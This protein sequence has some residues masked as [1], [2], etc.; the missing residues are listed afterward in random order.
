VFHFGRAIL[1]PQQDFYHAETGPL[2]R[3][4]LRGRD[5]AST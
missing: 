3:K 4:Y 1:H 2:I 5:G